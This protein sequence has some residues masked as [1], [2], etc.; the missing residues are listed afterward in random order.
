MGDLVKK[1]PKRLENG[2]R[3]EIFVGKKKLGGRATG[4]RARKISE[5]AIDFPGKNYKPN[6]SSDKENRGPLG[7]GTNERLNLTQ[8]FYRNKNNAS[9]SKIET[10]QDLR[11]IPLAG[12][13]EISI[14][15][16]ADTVMP[17]NGEIDFHINRLQQEKKVLESQIHEIDLRKQQNSL[18]ANQILTQPK[19]PKKKFSKRFFSTFN[20]KQ[21]GLNVASVVT[22]PEIWEKL[23]E[24]E[25]LTKNDASYQQ[26]SKM[27]YR[28]STGSLDF[29]LD[30]NFQ[31][32]R[33]LSPR[34]INQEN[35][36][37]PIKE[38]ST[39]G[40]QPSKD[41]VIRRRNF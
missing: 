5:F 12:R 23:L 4:N 34:L 14:R 16:N 31:S 24:S 19:Y 15:N 33:R 29:L 35:Y 1:E 11:P 40:L 39:F 27:S 13:G 18:K 36:L 17:P 28:S 7:V 8:K 32:F 6:A 3:D 22:D 9:V 25:N 37:Y 2:A 30:D 26:L 10:Q 21:K 41:I 38:E 20:S